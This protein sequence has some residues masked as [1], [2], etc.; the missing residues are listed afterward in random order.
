MSSY[1]MRHTSSGRGICLMLAGARMVRLTEFEGNT[2]MG[3]RAM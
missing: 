1:T 2:H 3:G